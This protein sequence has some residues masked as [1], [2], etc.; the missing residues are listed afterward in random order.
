MIKATDSD[1]APWYKVPADDKRSA[2]LNCIKH[3][4]SQIP[5]EEIPFELP[6]LPKKHKRG[7]G[8]PGT[9]PFLHTIP[10]DF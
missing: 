3:L 9:I 1:Y 8:I 2:R 10:Q 6:K 5:Y 4:L 7:D